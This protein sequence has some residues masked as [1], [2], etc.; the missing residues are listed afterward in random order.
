MSPVAFH[1][2]REG[3]DGTRRVELRE[4]V[5]IGRDVDDPALRAD[6][7]LSGRHAVVER[8]GDTVVLTDLGS[9][10][11]TFLRVAGELELRPGDVFAVGR[12]LFR[13]VG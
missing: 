9:T 2:L 8:T 7:Y 6:R 10:N 12:Q 1:L 13:F 4:P 11:G 5:L 3:P